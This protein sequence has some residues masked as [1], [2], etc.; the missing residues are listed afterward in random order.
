MLAV[1]LNQ[2]GYF[3]NMH[4]KLNYQNPSLLRANEKNKKRKK[5][6]ADQKKKMKERDGGRAETW[7]EG[8]YY[9]YYIVLFNV[10]QFNIL[11]EAR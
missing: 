2:C 6:E 5:E 1:E 8:R 10:G 3:T 4:P 7:L 9:Y 11:I